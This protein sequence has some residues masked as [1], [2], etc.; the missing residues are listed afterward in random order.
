MKGKLHL[1]TKGV[2]AFFL[3]LTLVVC[4]IGFFWIGRKPIGVIIV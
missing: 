4:F 3:I 1:C 2:V